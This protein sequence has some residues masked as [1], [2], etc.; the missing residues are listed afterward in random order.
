MKKSIIEIIE[1][2][3]KLSYFS[4][5]T[6]TDILVELCKEKFVYNYG[7]KALKNIDIMY[8]SETFF[9]NEHN[10]KE[11]ISKDSEVSF[12]S[13]IYEDFLLEN[14]KDKT[15]TFYTPDFIIEY[16]VDKALVKYLSTYTRLDEDL[17]KNSLEKKISLDFISIQEM[18]NALDKVKIIDIACGTGLFLIHCLKRIFSIKKDLNLLMGKYINDFK[19]MKYIIENNLFGIDIQV[20]PIE[21][22]KMVLASIAY[23]GI[24][25]RDTLQIKFNLFV[26]DS[27]IDEALYTGES[28]HKVEIEKEGF[29]IVIGNPPYMGEKGNKSM[30]HKIKETPFGKE[31][32]EG[33]MDY[34]YFFIYKGL[35]LLN[36]DGFLAYITTNYFVTADGAKK[37]RNYFREKCSFLEIFNFNNYEIFPL[38][39]G[40]H[41]MIFFVKNNFSENEPVKIIHFNKDVKQK[42]LV[43][44]FK[45]NNLPLNINQYLQ[46]QAE[47][48]DN[49]G[50]IIIQE[51]YKYESIIKKILKRS[52]STLEEICNINQGIV[53]G[54]DKVTN[55]MLEK[56][57]SKDSIVKNNIEKE[58]GI[59]VLSEQEA[60]ELDLW[61][62]PFLK[63]MYKNS[64]IQRY[65]PKENTNKF[66]LYVGDDFENNDYRNNKILQHLIR[67]KNVLDKRR[68]TVN[69]VRKW[70][71]LQWPR[72]IQIFEG[73]KIVVPQ[74][75]RFN[76][77]AYTNTPWYASADV[78]FITHKQ[79]DIDFYYLLGQLNSKIMYFYLFNRGKR[80]GEDL[81]LYANPLKQLPI[82]F[83][84][85]AKSIN[86]II[87]GVKAMI[88]LGKEKQSIQQRID[89]IMYKAYKL[90][91]DEI[92]MVEELFPNNKKSF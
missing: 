89:S 17:I 11:F 10:V 25:N 21:I 3:K 33:K 54:A 71:A 34:F 28:I 19:D 1:T 5:K 70:Y 44:I 65:V 39:K 49:K 42:N 51:N 72:N 92:I 15:G 8:K 68:E 47:L 55:E 36:T 62:S 6:D 77:F 31:Y 91:K 20:Q 35:N 52:D 56:K 4:Y 85:D 27:L 50:N 43:P 59:F 30:F 9:K 14:H 75:A 61:D 2:I 7:I 46:S 74:R 87:D 57:L 18:I 13:K 69:N 60:K 73:G 38:A 40:Q 23:D 81:E 41:N 78:Y 79:N 12:F 48:Y 86:E 53:S 24:N 26:G 64:D 32:Y 16:I 66:I 58:Q 80:K 88:E 76:R 45:N 84:I 83:N 37:L 63:P 22:G 29:D 90:T 67:F 82:L